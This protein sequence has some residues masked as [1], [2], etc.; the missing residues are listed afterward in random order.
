VVGAIVKALVFV[1]ARH[2]VERD[3]HPGDGKRFK[4]NRDGRGV[5]ECWE[6]SFIVE[7]ME[8]TS[9]ST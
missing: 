2:A 1:L 9:E 5:G 3:G 4:V 6:E 8:I 7:A